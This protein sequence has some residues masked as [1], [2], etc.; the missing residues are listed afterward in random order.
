[1]LGSLP[2]GRTSPK[3]FAPCLAPQTLY[4]LESQARRFEC[5]SDGLVRHAIVYRQCAEA[6]GLVA[7]GDLRPGGDRHLESWR[8]GQVNVDGIEAQCQRCIEG[9][10]PMGFEPTFSCVT[11]RY[12]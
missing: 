5:P 6:L 4:P 11:G 7:L 3:P 10:T 9:A 2:N 12:V 8:S 1:M